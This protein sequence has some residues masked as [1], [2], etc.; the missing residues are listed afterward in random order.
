VSS[1]HRGIARL[2]AAAHANPPLQ[3]TATMT[4]FESTEPVECG[5]RA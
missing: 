3:A 4:R 2:A 5:G 1:L